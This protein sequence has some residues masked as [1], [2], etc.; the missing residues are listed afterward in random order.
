MIKKNQYPGL[1]IALEGLDGSGSSSQ[2]ELLTNSLK[3]NGHKVFLTKEPTNNI[4]GGLIRG[5]LTDVWKSGMECLQL[6]FAA[7][8][9][10]HL[11]REII[12]ALKDN[13]IVISDRYFFS[14][15]AFG[16]IELD[17]NWL[18]SLNEKII[19]PDITIL[20]RV[21]PEEC[22]TRIEENRFRF[23]LFEERK[24]L[25]KVWLNYLWLQKKFPNVYL[26]DGE[27]DKEKIAADILKIYQKL[28]L[29][30]KNK[31][32]LA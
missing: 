4:I 6:L 16:A 8:R 24:K 20:I 18:I 25:K 10:H 12:P 5:Q 15:I 28:I 27:R 19:Y 3:A 9:Y 29:S 21:S 22:L 30:K 14:T 31:K 26:I 32:V 13:R 7:D 23:E 17:R 11:E 2:A 1:F